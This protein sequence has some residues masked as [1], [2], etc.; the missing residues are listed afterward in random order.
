MN[1]PAGVILMAQGAEREYRRGRSFPLLKQSPP[2]S[3]VSPPTP[4][5][6]AGTLPQLGHGPAAPPEDIGEDAPAPSLPLV[7]GPQPGRAHTQT[8]TGRL[9]PLGRLSS[10]QKATCVGGCGETGAPVH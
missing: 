4:R 8:P 9:P 3:S 6:E 10:K 1:L 2:R 7:N 5:S